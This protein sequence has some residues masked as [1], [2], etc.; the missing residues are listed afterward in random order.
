MI[1]LMMTTVLW[2]KVSLGMKSG[3][4]KG[5]SAFDREWVN[6][7]KDRQETLRKTWPT[8]PILMQCDSICTWGFV[9]EFVLEQA[10]RLAIETKQKIEDSWIFCHFLCD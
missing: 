8:D 2:R 10:C 6:R 9:D 7:N 1:K 3:V 5:S 4:N